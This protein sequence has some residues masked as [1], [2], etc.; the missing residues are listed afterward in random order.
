[1]SLRLQIAS[2]GSSSIRRHGS[3]G[4]AASGSY[5]GTG[6]CG[7]VLG[8]RAGVDYVRSDMRAQHPRHGPAAAMWWRRDLGV[9]RARLAN[10][11]SHGKR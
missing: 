1:M 9:V 3:G 2:G 11:G 4:A 6:E 8:G 5:K 7:I 10:F